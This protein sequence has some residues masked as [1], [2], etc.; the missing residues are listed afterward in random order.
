[1]FA[2]FCSSPQMF[3]G[4]HTC[5]NC[6]ALAKPVYSCNEEPST[7][8]ASP[9]APSIRVFGS[10]FACLG[11]L[12][13]L[14]ACPLVAFQLNRSALNT[15]LCYFAARVGHSSDSRPHF[16]FY[17]DFVSCASNCGSRTVRT[18]QRRFDCPCVD[19]DRI[20]LNRPFSVPAAFNI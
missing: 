15:W 10:P 19:A 11:R 13:Q 2:D 12:S 18:R 8:H 9:I 1:M 5:L 3:Y 16:P 4:R 17:V 14:A 20:S 7:T 6:F